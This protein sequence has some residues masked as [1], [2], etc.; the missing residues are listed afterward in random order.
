[1]YFNSCV[2]SMWH[3]EGVSDLQMEAGNQFCITV[4]MKT[5]DTHTHTHNKKHCLIE[6]LGPSNV[7]VCLTTIDLS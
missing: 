7:F 3:L 6:L 5:V 4:C 1:M 2:N